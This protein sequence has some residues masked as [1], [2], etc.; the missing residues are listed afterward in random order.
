MHPIPDKAEVAVDFPD[1]LYIGGF[2]RDSAFEVRSE[3]DG[4]LVRLL[5]AGPDRREVKIYLHHM[6]LTDVLCDLAETVARGGIDDSHRTPLL[7]AAQRL[8]AA[9]DTKSVAS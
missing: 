7:D 4:V 1:K 3:P 9:L 5:R 2:G 8:V 6:L